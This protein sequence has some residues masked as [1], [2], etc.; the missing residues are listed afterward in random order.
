MVSTPEKSTTENKT[1]SPTTAEV[2]KAEGSATPEKK[3]PSGLRRG[4]FSPQ[5]KDKSPKKT[6]TAESKPESKDNAVS[7]VTEPKQVESVAKSEKDAPK[8]VEKP[9]KTES[10]SVEKPEKAD[11]IEKSE[12]TASASVDEKT[13]TVE[14]PKEA[15]AEDKTETG[16]EKAEISADKKETQAETSADKTESADSKTEDVVPSA[17]SKSDTKNSSAETVHGSHSLLV[18]RGRTIHIHRVHFSF[19][20]NSFLMI[21]LRHLSWHVFLPFTTFFLGFFALLSTRR[22]LSDGSSLYRLHG[23]ILRGN[24]IGIFSLW[25][26]CATVLGVRFTFG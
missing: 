12:K 9:E 4:F 17:E 3:K 24:F 13:E 14:Q 1:E 20:F 25:R 23:H 10:E 11:S 15:V 6:D 5:K 16:V 22:W 8:P 18:E 7:V 26:A 19:S 21:L 2:K